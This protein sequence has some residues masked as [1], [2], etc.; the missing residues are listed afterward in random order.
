[1]E[2]KIYVSEMA[3]CSRYYNQ[4]NKAL[5]VFRNQL[6][7]DTKVT[8]VS[9]ISDGATYLIMPYD[10]YCNLEAKPERSIHCRY[11]LLFEDDPHYL[12]KLK[13][14]NP[15]NEYKWEWKNVNGYEV[16]SR[17]DRRFSPFYMILEDGTSIEEFYQ[18]V[19]KGGVGKGNPCEDMESAHVR[20]RNLMNDYIF[21]HYGLFYELALIGMTK[22]F[23]DM[24]DKFGGQN[25]TYADCLNNYFRLDERL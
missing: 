5:R 6:R 25:K 7:K 14:L 20:L 4:L 17:G 10:Q 21:T 18:K 9:R 8:R 11:Y 12:Q 15:I 24:F 16:T 19:V 1:M 23:T 3:E 13:E 2:E 22:S